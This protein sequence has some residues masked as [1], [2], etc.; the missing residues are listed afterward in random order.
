MID[1]WSLQNNLRVIGERIPHFRSVTAG[2]WVRAGSQ[3]ETAETSGISHLIE[4]MLFKGTKKR[5][6][7]EIAEDVDA[8]GGQINA[9][10]S[11]ECTC[12]YV[13]VMDEHLP[14]AM[15]ILSDIAL[16]STLKP[17]ELEKERGVVCEEIAMVEDTPEDLVHELLAKVHFEGDP[18]ARTILG[19]ANNIRSFPRETLLGYMDRFYAPR[20]CVLSLAGNYEPARAS[21]L[22]E[23]SFGGWRDS[24]APTPPVNGARMV[25]STVVQRK[26]I[27]QVHLC[28]GF[29][30]VTSLDDDLYALSILNN[31][32]GGGMSSRL[33]QSIREERGL[34]YSVYTY[35]TSYTRAGAMSIYAGL[36]AENAHEVC[37]LIF[38][39]LDN[40]LAHGVE[41]REFDMAREQLKG[42]FILG[43]ESTS[44]RMTSM[45]RS[46]LMRGRIFTETEVLDKIGRVTIEDVNRVAKRCFSD[47]FSAAAV[48]KLPENFEFRR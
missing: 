37:D 33:F 28:M 32:L 6:A 9:F 23:E 27:E 38:N 44:S 31:L 40:L 29:P 42:G 3:N 12:F 10:T 14:L 1:Q 25:K 17:E 34:A 41:A 2:L 36:N 5:S 48:G 26:D 39:E 7:R 15:D 43:Q 4:H 35:P 16:N 45:G 18:Y 22:I 11:K 21:A 8:V 13:K 20:N 30:G 46:L 47:G 24:G 19:P